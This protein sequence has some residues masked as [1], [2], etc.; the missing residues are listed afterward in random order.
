M[1]RRVRCLLLRRPQLAARGFSIAEAL[2]ATLIVTI[3]LVA[4]GTVFSAIG[5]RADRESGRSPGVG[6]AT[7]AAL[8]RLERDLVL[9]EGLPRRSGRLRAD[10]RTLLLKMRDG[11]IV[12]WRQEGS[13]L[14]RGTEDERRR[15][16]DKTIADRVLLLDL[17]PRGERLF[18]VALRRRQEPL[19]RRT[20]LLRNV[21]DEDETGDAGDPGASGDPGAPAEDAPGGGPG[22]RR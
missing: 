16:I 13:L 8:E 15:L 22:A 3:V 2:V 19:R 7:D 20:V 9:A 14:L 5:K 6:G 4:A 10:G 1:T 21:S 12:T 11:S 17:S 18:D